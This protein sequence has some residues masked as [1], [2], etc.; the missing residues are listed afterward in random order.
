[1]TG[2]RQIARRLRVP[3]GFAFAAGYIVLARPTA[4][5]IVAGIGIALPGLALR[6]RASG[7]VEKNQVLTV[8]GP[9]SYTRNPL[10]LGSLV[11]A[12]GFTI[13]ARSWW[14]AAIAAVLLLVIYFPVILSEEEFLR[15]RF[16]EFA[17]YEK[18]VPRLFP[19]LRPRAPASGAF[20]W[21]LYWKHREYNAALGFLLMAAILVVKALWIQ[22]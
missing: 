15:L 22:S 21:H 3:F 12:A 4:A 19:R 8:S 20:S 1:M 10:Y 5:S 2:W 16:P 7:Y 17:Q 9:Y 18:E 13:A 14:I 6:A 11:L